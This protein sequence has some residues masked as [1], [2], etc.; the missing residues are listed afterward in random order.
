MKTIDTAMAERELLEP[1]YIDTNIDLLT[2]TIDYVIEH[3]IDDPDERAK[4]NMEL[5][6]CLRE[7]RENFKRIK[8]KTHEQQI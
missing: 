2:D 4:D 7:L 5:I 6:Y 8:N 1:A 3:S